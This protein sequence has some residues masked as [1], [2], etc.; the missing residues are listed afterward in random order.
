M[1]KEL[2]EDFRWQAMSKTVGPTRISYSFTPE[3]LEKFAELLIKGC[4]IEIQRCTRRDGNSEHNLALYEVMEI[5][6]NK[7]GVHDF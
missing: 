7:Y 1:N 4:L 5:I 6:S 3:E 2:I